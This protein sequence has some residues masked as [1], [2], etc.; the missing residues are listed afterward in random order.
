MLVKGKEDIFIEIK[1][2]KIKE[3]RPYA[4]FSLNLTSLLSGKK[5]E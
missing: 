3:R 1:K 2:N 5:K 4:L